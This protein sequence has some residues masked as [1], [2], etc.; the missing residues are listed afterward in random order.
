MKPIDNRELGIE[1]KNLE[2][3][4]ITTAV[5]RINQMLEMD[6]FEEEV[7]FLF[8]YYRPIWFKYLPLS[9]FWLLIRGGI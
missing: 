3:Q 5:M 9:I 1:L 2:S 6:M 7:Y 8:F 4:I